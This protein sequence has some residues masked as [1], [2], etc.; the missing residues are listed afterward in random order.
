MRISLAIQEMTRLLSSIYPDREAASIA[1]YYFECKTGLSRLQM[2]QDRETETD[3]DA[4]KNDVKRLLKSEPVQYVTGIAWFY[5]LPLRIFHGV[6]IPRPETEELVE[7]AIKIQKE[8]PSAILDIGTGSGCIAVAIKKNM[9]GL[10]VFASDIS[11]KAIANAAINAELFGTEINFIKDNILQTEIKDKFG[12]IVSNPPYVTEKEKNLMRRNVLDYEPE[13]A[14]Y[15]PD[16][17]PLLFYRA[18]ADFA[19]SGLTAGGQ[20]LFEINEAYHNE[21]FDLL[22]S[23]DFIN[24]DARKDI[25]GK[26]RIVKAQKP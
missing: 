17:D 5:D 19:L 15:V 13:T 22:K 2:V 4:C 6:L 18:I 1:Q 3:W 26:W 20:L 14:L 7:L 24:I 12:M 8:R 23:R 16:Q 25:N 10:T 9:P 11:D 21:I